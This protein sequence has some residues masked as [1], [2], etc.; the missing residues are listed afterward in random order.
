[1]LTVDTSCAADV[2]VVLADVLHVV[3]CHL[4]YQS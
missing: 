4:H 3:V 2:C 1:L